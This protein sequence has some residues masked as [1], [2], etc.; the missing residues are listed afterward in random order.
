LLYLGICPFAVFFALIF[1]NSLHS[2]YSKP[3]KLKVIILI[4]SIL[5][6]LYL[7][8]NIERARV[9]NNSLSL[10]EDTVK[11][12]PTNYRAHLNLGSE[13]QRQNMHEKAIPVLEIAA[14]LE[15]Q[16]F[17][18]FNNLGISFAS[19]NKFNEAEYFFKQALRINPYNYASITNLAF[20]YAKKN[21]FAN[22]EKT[23]LKA[24]ALNP[25]NSSSWISLYDMYKQTIPPD[26]TKQILEIL[27]HKYSRSAMSYFILGL[28]SYDTKNTTQAL[29]YFKTSQEINPLFFK[30]YYYLSEIY[31]TLHQ[32]KL[33]EQMQQ[34]YLHMKPANEE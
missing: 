22:A 28:F 10:W 27:N 31:Q 25:N 34:K 23:Y 21:D 15:P 3:A 14:T 11:K 2:I 1:N 13:Y 18:A 24:I 26:K 4:V 16:S 8:K 5:S 17:Q 30:T 20:L 12:S 7:Y 6:V 32:D 9:W 19:L 29:T 33:A